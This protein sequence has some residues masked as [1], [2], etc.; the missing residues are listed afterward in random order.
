VTG[1]L[2]PVLRTHAWVALSEPMQ[3]QK[4]P[5]VIVS[6]ALLACSLIAAD[7]ASATKPG[8]VLAAME[9]VN[10][11]FAERD[12]VHTVATFDV[13]PGARH[14]PDFPPRVE[15]LLNRGFLPNS[16]RFVSHHR[17]WKVPE[18]PRMVLHRLA[19][20]LGSA[21]E[22][23]GSSGYGSPEGHSHSVFSY[24]KPEVDGLFSKELLLIATGLP[25]DK[26]ALRVE[27]Q[28]YWLKP[29]SPSER[30][31]MSARQ[32]TVTVQRKG[33]RRAHSISTSDRSLIHSV[34]RLIN[35]QEVIQIYDRPS[36]GPPPTP[37]EVSKTFDVA[38]RLHRGGPP[39]A[40]ASQVRPAGPCEPLSLRI[41][42]KERVP[43]YGGILMVHRVRALIQQIYQRARS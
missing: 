32:M 41:H 17:D 40:V 10:R 34:A 8:P 23:G 29:R 13:L 6:L 25:G 43:L 12:A 35:S 5:V 21:W 3:G 16:R 11:R 18:T 14:E 7:G 26:T 9:K 22:E 24:W 28:N 31:P 36:C 30:V 27:I 15:R 1:R 19:H 20:D 2:G 39:V 37:A 33:S 42:G 38:F 4:I